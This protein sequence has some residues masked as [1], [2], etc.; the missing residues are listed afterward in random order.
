MKHFEA[1]DGSII[2]IS[3]SRI[4]AFGLSDEEILIVKN[5]VPMG[6]YELYVPNQ[7]EDILAIRRDALI[8][9]SATIVPGERNLI[10]EYYTELNGCYDESVFWIG[11]P[12]PPS[13][14]RA[15]FFCYE[16]LDALSCVL[17]E[18]LVK[19][20][21]KAKKSRAFSKNLSDCIQILSMIR[22]KPGI[23]TTEMSEKLELPIRTVQRHIAAL[24]A[25]GE[26]IE[27]DAKKR[28]WQLQYG[29]SIL[30]GDH[31]KNDD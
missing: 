21:Q 23:K 6:D 25:A 7:V 15:R 28:G 1:P 26:W 11:Y 12:M 9:N 22:L 30:F 4:I 16:N 29:V 10:L 14:L 3:D 5:G 8:I 17:P 20:H 13:H 19:A 18:K 27:Y 24:Q 2:N 31:L